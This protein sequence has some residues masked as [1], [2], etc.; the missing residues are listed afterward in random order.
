[1]V[2]RV[3]PVIVPEHYPAFQGLA[4]SLPDTYSVWNARHLDEI[5][6]AIRLDERLIDVVVYPDAFAEF[7]REQ[8]WDG[9]LKTLE[10][11]AIQK[12]TRRWARLMT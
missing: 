1:M 10:A 8:G 7:L 2:G 6:D 9:N 5:Q 4:P 3:L 12:G 11:F